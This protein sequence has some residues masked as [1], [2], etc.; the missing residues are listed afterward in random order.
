MS[1][2]TWIRG[3]RPQTLPLALAPVLIGVAR[4]WMGVF[5]YSQGGDVDHPPCPTFGGRPEAYGTVSSVVNGAMASSTQGACSTS[6]G[7]FVAV[8]VLCALVALFLQIAVNFA[9]DYS[10]GVRGVDQGRTGVVGR[11]GTIG[12][13]GVV[14]QAVGVSQTGGG[15]AANASPPAPARLVASGVPPR[16]VLI[17]AG[18]SAALACLAGLGVVELTGYWWFILVGVACLLAGWFYV[19]GRHPYGY[20]GWGEVSVFVFFGL[21]ATIGTQF[22]LT[23]TVSLSGIWGG[24]TVGLVAVSVLT[25]N[26]LRDVDE[27]RRHGKR[28]WPVRLGE[29]GGRILLD[30]L[31][32]GA[33]AMALLLFRA[34]YAWQVIAVGPDC[35][36]TYP[37]GDLRHAVEV[38]DTAWH[39]TQTVMYYS[40]IVLLTVFVGLCAAAIVAVHRRRFRPALP[41]CTISSLVLAA[42]YWTL[43]FLM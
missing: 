17:A 9:N 18:A 42:E 36:V 31:L 33:A 2:S 22:A 10:D 40:S 5:S 8:S 29:R 15:T 7:W 26:N 43:S 16:T 34:S 37:N 39:Q 6:V 19:G 4:S 23:G 1:I 20:H 30:V 24:V 32:G 13:A 14:G 27:D 21:V 41:L 25:V 11:A 35:G 38:C 12:N 28:T 3:M